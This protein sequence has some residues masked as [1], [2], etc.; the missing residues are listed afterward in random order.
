MSYITAVTCVTSIASLDFLL[1]LRSL[2]DATCLVLWLKFFLGLL[3]TQANCVSSAENGH[4]C[5][6]T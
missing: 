6:L 3:I 4:L 1:S 2:S 5:R